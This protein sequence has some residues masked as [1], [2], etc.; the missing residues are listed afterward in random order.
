MKAYLRKKYSVVKL[1]YYWLD[2]K[3]AEGF[4]KAVRDHWI[5]GKHGFQ[6]PSRCCIMRDALHW[7]D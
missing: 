2:L 4:T 5:L 6:N 7:D 1:V 3:E